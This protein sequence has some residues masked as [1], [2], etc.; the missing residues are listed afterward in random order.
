MPHSTQQKPT[1]PTNVHFSKCEVKSDLIKNTFW[2]S[3]VLSFN[4][5]KAGRL[6][7]RVLRGKRRAKMFFGRQLTAAFYSLSD[8]EYAHAKKINYRNANI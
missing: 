1:P 7:E 3:D 2:L 4:V 6:N 8:A 5:C